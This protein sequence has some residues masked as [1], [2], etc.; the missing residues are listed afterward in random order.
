MLYVLDTDHVSLLQRGHKQ[1]VANLARIDVNERAVTIIT[2]AEQMQ[3]RLAVIRRAR[4]EAEAARAFVSLQNTIAFYQTVQVLPYNE[5]AYT[6][7]A[8]LR[9]QKIRIGTQDLRIATIA[10]SHQAILATRNTRDFSLIPELGLED[11]TL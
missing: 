11:W 1:V 6:H 2:A 4:T 8:R 9:Q 5:E 3:G 7:F 10:L